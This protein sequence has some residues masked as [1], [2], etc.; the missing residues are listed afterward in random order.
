MAGAT[1]KAG[2]AW[3]EDDDDDAEGL[4]TD[5]GN[6]EAE[7]LAT[8]S[9]GCAGTGGADDEEEEEAHGAGRRRISAS[10]AS[11]MLSFQS[12]VS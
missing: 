2:A 4:G 8:L 6:D 11:A 3:P 9:V 12:L 1:H 7:T 5:G 10:T